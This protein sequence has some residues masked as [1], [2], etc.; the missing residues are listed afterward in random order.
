MEPLIVYIRKSWERFLK[1]LR[2]N[3]SVKI[4]EKII[5]SCDSVTVDFVALS[6]S[7]DSFSPEIKVSLR[8]FGKFAVFPGFVFGYG[9]LYKRCDIEV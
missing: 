7:P 6:D 9:I 4:D 2:V 3:Q 8:A 5:I 1:C